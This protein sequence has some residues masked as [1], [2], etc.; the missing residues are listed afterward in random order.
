MF[1]VEGGFGFR[2]RVSGARV[3]VSTQHQPSRE[4]QSFPQSAPSSASRSLVP[5]S[6]PCLQGRTLAGSLAVC[7]VI[8]CCVWWLL[9][10]KGGRAVFWGLGQKV[11]MKHG[12]YTAQV[13]SLAAGAAAAAPGGCAWVP[14]RPRRERAERPWLPSGS[15]FRVSIFD[16]DSPCRLEGLRLLGKLSYLYWK[17]GKYWDVRCARAQA[18]R[19]ARWSGSSR[20]SSPTPAEDFGRCWE[21]GLGV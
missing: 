12:P 7:A 5:P 9:G 17:Y 21:L 8:V 1:R 15:G 10:L 16:F 11:H 13:C 2:V 14:G 19:K 3:Y 4:T 18:P 20:A 6:P